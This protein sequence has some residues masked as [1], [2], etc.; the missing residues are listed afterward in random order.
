[1]KSVRFCSL[2]SAV[3]VC[4]PAV[5][6]AQFQIEELAQPRG[7]FGGGGMRFVRPMRVWNVPRKS[8]P[9]IQKPAKPVW[10]IPPGQY[11]LHMADGLRIIG[12][13]AKGWSV[14]LKTAFGNVTIPLTQ[15]VRLE[16]AANAEF[17]AHLKNG[18]RVTGRLTS[19]ILEFETQFGTLRIP[20][21]DLLR[22]STPSPVKPTVPTV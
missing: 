1:M 3:V 4:L 13:P 5:A 20:S 9:T 10:R 12:R 19:K 18:D 8:R 15:I 21:G 17:A 6:A 11:G 16:P 2:I 14:A 7:G 22:L